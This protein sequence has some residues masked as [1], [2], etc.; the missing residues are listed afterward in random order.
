MRIL[1]ERALWAASLGHF[2]SNYN[3]Y[4][5]LSWLPF[6]LVRARGFSLQSMGAIA[7]F[8]YL[9]NAAAA[10]LAGWAIDALVRSGHSA[11]TLYKAAMALN[12][13]ASILAMIG[14]AL[15]PLP[16]SLAC[17]FIF[18]IVLGLSSPGIYA[19]AQIMAG[20]AAAGRWVGVQN[21]CANI[22]GIVAP[23]LTGILIDATG[24]FTSAFVLAALVNV[25]GLVAWVW[26][27]PPVAPL[28]WEAARPASAL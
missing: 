1:R 8:A 16:G 9:I 6:Y 18:Q 10:L 21:C 11:S 19:I 22:A 3:F 4:F 2:A 7:G 20:P 24:S 17:L 5:I 13:V 14:M 12:H 23:Q 25:F 26:I 28:R 27:L 15:L